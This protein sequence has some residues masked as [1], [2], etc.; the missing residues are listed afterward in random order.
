MAEQAPNTPNTP[1]KPKS[2]G[3][4]RL[5]PQSNKPK[6]PGSGGSN[7]YWIY[8]V[9]TLLFIGS[10]F[11][12]VGNSTR[13]IKTDKFSAILKA[14]DVKDITVVNKEVAELTIKK[15]KLTKPEYRDLQTI[16]PA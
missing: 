1:E 16:D 13:E 8:G 7:F 9:I 3:N 14:G 10:Y 12:N 5:F 11:Y 6:T 2:T 4:R 15:E